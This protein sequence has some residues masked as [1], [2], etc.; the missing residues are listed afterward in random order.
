MSIWHACV[1]D[2]ILDTSMEGVHIYDVRTRHTNAD[3]ADAVNVD[4]L[5]QSAVV[6]AMMVWH[7]AMR[8]EPIPRRR[9]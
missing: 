9:P 1:A 5:K 6:L 2:K 3:L 7:A 8:D 4:D